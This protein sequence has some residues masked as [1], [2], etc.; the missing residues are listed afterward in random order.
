MS[1]EVPSGLNDALSDRSIQPVEKSLPQG[2]HK[3]ER[4]YML[5]I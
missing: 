2:N 3:S 5:E 4:H 1:E